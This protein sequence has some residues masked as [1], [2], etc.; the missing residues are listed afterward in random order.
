ML[1]PRQEVWKRGMLPKASHIGEVSIKSYFQNRIWEI[2]IGQFNEE[3]LVMGME[4]VSTTI[5]VDKKMS[6]K[7]IIWE[8]CTEIIIPTK[9]VMPQLLLLIFLCK[10]QN[11]QFAI[12][13]KNLKGNRE[14]GIQQHWPKKP[15]SHQVSAVKNYA[16]RC[17][18]KT[19]SF[20]H[21]QNW[22]INQQTMRQ[23]LSIPEK[24]ES[25]TDQLNKWRNAV[26]ERNNV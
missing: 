20:L 17:Y 5:M 23:N 13:S 2:C 18:H 3:G 12:K 11:Q 26:S 10:S 24:V 8:L 4:Q 1:F 15:K 21:P 16:S 19:I 9:E 22:D 6:A 14:K 7:R 25:I